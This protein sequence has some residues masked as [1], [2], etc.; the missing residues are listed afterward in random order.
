M[1]KDMIGKIYISMLIL[2]ISSCAVQSPYDRSYVSKGIKERTDYELGQVAEPG[3]FN[4]PEEVSLED[5]LSQDEAVAIALWNNAQFQADLAALGFTRADLIEA[6]MLAN[7]TFSLL[8]PI[9]PKALETALDVPIDALWQRP[10]HIAAAKLDAQ[11]LAENLIEDGLGLIRDVQTTYSELWLAQVRVILAT[12]DAQLQIEMAKLDEASLRAG[13]ISGLAASVSYVD[14]LKAD[15]AL[16]RFSKEADILEQRLNSLLGI[17][18]DDMA[19]DIVTPDFTSKSAISIDELLKTAFAARPDLWAAELAIEAAGER[20]GWEKSKVY[21]FIAIIDAKDE[22]DDF[23]T[24]GPGFAIDIPIFNQNKGQ[25]ARAKAEL[26]QAARQYEA[27]RQNI[28]LQVRQAHTQY[29]SAYDEFELWS[30]DIIP[31]LQTKV[32]QTQKSYEAGE[33][34]YISVLE[35]KREFVEAKM[36]RMELAGNLQRNAAELN[37]CIGKKM[38]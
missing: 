1:G 20:V 18:S 24:I 9:G 33:V 32:K 34:S 26:E 25:I 6:G 21:N 7:P 11:S 15:D 2:L 28:I 8:F 37:Y 14:T 13:D 23:L 3:E 27:V 16:K 17:T 5:G 38:I 19:F 36:H 30:S 10:H 35:A 12:E 4:F 31:S 22:G 29:V